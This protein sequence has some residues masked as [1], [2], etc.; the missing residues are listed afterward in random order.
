M[1]HVFMLRR[2]GF[3]HF[4]RSHCNP[5][6]ELTKAMSEVSPTTDLAGS[7]IVLPE[8]FNLGRA[9]DLSSNPKDEPRLHERCVLECLRQIAAS[10]EVAFVVGVIEI[11]TRRNSAYFVDAGTPRLMCHKIINDQSREYE[12]CTSDCQG[13]NPITYPEGTCV[14]ALICADAIDNRP[15]PFEGAKAAYE[16]R[17]KLEAKLC[18]KRSLVCVPAHMDTRDN[19]PHICGSGL[20]LANSRSGSSSLIKDRNGR[21]LPTSGG[22]QNHIHLEEVCKIMEE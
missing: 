21:E 8:G 15:T 14:G 12:P 9:Y 19:H 22:L 7:L 11:D 5:L 6:G 1:H 16:R 17:C 10:Y 3:F 18:G 20:I 13:E 2:A 4:V